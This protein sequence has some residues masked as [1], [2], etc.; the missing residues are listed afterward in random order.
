MED[1]TVHRV[2]LRGGGRNAKFWAVPPGGQKVA[3][4]VMLMGTWTP[5][6]SPSKH[7]D[8][9]GSTPVAPR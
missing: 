4:P 7:Y 8:S 2:L 5:F 6:P 9:D 3:V 1:L